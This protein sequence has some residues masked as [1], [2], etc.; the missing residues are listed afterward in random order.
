MRFPGNSTDF[1]VEYTAS[2]LREVEEEEEGD[3]IFL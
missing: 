2:V 1:K 3:S